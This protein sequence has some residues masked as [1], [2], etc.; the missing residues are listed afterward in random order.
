MRH[1]WT[2]KDVCGEAKGI[3]ED[4]K[5]REQERISENKKQRSEV[6][7]KKIIMKKVGFH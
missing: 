4:L 3:I 2:P 5:Q 1:E 6:E 7:G